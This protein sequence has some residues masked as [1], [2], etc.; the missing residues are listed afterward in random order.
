MFTLLNPHRKTRYRHLRGK[1]FELTMRPD[2]TTRQE[3]A[4]IDGAHHGDE[5]FRLDSPGIF[6]KSDLVEFVRLPC[7]NVRRGLRSSLA[8]PVQPLG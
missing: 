2:P 4:S 5:F 8:S 3:A 7:R 1:N 6:C